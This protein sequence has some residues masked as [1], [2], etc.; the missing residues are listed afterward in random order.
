MLPPSPGLTQTLPNVPPLARQERFVERTDLQA[1]LRV[2]NAEIT[3]GELP[4]L[5]LLLTNRGRARLRVPN[6]RVDR[7]VSVRVFDTDGEPVPPRMGATI[8][9]DVR[10]TSVRNLPDLPPGRSREFPLSVGWNLPG[11]LPAGDY[12]F[13][14][15]YANWAGSP[16]LYDVHERGADEVWEGDLTASVGV[17]I[18]PVDP[19]TERRLIEQVGDESRTSAAE[20][21]RVL[22]LSR[23]AAAV[24]SIVERLERDNGMFPIALEALGYIGTP[25]A[26]RALA[27][28]HERVPAGS[29]Y[30]LIWR[31]SADPDIRR[32]VR[33][34]GCDALALGSLV[35]Y[36]RGAEDLRSGC[37][38]VAGV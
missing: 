27:V 17:S 34:T 29:P 28:A 36:Y 14:A 20:A 3:A 8:D 13:R 11:A 31:F 35:S 26:A 21:M 6:A 37:G 1:T 22:G 18:R 16:E 4:Q 23:A 30:R 2:S 10:P 7:S 5:S 33:G 9:Y 19:A 25:H 24:D 12:V 38:E 15:T 32:L